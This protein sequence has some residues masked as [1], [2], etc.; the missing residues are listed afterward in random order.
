MALR[1]DLVYIHRLRAESL[2]NAAMPVFLDAAHIFTGDGSSC[3]SAIAVASAVGR[4]PYYSMNFR[5]CNTWNVVAS[6]GCSL[7]HL[8]NIQYI[9]VMQGLRSTLS[10]SWLIIHDC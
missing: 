4:G 10:V 3:S 7:L 5:K 1:T 2:P 6:I 9:C 8:Q